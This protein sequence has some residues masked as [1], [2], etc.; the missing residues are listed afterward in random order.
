MTF[1]CTAQKGP[2]TIIECG[3]SEK[4]RDTFMKKY[5]AVGYT[6][7]Y[8]VEGPGTYITKT[9]VLEFHNEHLEYSG[10]LTMTDV[11]NWIERRR[12]A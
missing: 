7:I 12:S 2:Q 10:E 4:E 9:D 5:S 8:Q 1:T 11:E 6:A 3:L